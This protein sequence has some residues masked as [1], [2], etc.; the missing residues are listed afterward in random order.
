MLEFQ[1]GRATLL[2]HS[3][4]RPGRFED[5]TESYAALVRT[6]AARAADLAP[7]ARFGVAGVRV[8]EAFLWTM[9]LV[10]GGAAAL[11]LFSLSA[12][13]AAMGVAMA[14]RMLFVLLLMLAA[15]PW[16]TPRAPAIDPRAIPEALLPRA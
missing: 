14:A 11:V 4:S 16:M 12:G 1:R 7:A 2:S 9:G 8:Q 5:R 10:G 13:A 6:L 3:W 15:L